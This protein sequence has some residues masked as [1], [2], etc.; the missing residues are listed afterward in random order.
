MN[1]SDA[2]EAAAILVA[3]AASIAVILVIVRQWVHLRDHHIES[4]FRLWRGDCS[5]NREKTDI[6]VSRIFDLGD[7]FRQEGVNRWVLRALCF[8]LAIAGLAVA[9][10]ELN[11]V[12]L[13][14]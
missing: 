3:G 9:V 1:W 12:H 6:A 8:A 13:W 2:R 14:W 7:G 10:A 4:R 5:A 11:G